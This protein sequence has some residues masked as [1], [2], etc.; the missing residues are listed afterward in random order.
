MG[1]P[2]HIG[3]LCPT[4]VGQTLIN[5]YR[6]LGWHIISDNHL[7]D[8]GG[9]FGK[10][11][12]GFQRYGNPVELEKDAVEHLLSVY[13]KI[14]ADAEENPHIEQECRDAFRNLAGGNPEYMKLWADF[15]SRTVKEADAL[16]ARVN[17]FCDYAVGESYFEGLPLP[18]IGN[19]PELQY[20]MK[21]VVAELIELGIATRNEDGSVGVVFAEE[22]KIP[23][24]VLA[25][26][27]GTHGYLASDL[28]CMKYRFTNGWNPDAI[29]ICTDV[30]QE[31]HF[32]QL[33]ASTARWIELA[34]WT[35][36]VKTP[37]LVHIKNGFIKLKDGA[38]SSRKGN[39]V[40][41]ADLLDEATERVTQIIKEKGSIL[42]TSDAE[43]IAI[44]AV[45][46]SLLMQDAER[47]ITFDWDKA[48][49]L[50]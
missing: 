40:R 21:S 26:K 16:I 14:T 42:S 25:K 28:A 36:N 31:L 43:A 11:I 49:N 18:K 37:E 41:L 47:D 8:W 34:D 39:I 30:R 24:C 15:T 29:M 38:M 23:S 9:L 35:K 27:D 3:H 17:V 5:V 4:S 33:F 20:T 6:Y 44:G 32:R 2:L 22:S 7:G 45:K 1:K 12:V 13:V 19:Q 10:L 46:Y 50:E 48:L